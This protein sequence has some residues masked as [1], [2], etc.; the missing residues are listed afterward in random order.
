[1]SLKLLQLNIFHGRFLD[2]IIS[3]IKEND[4][5]II[6]LQEVSS[7]ALSFDKKNNLNELKKALFYQNFFIKTTQ[8]VDK[9]SSSYGLATFIKHTISIKKKE[10]IW[11]KDF[12]TTI[13]KEAI[14]WRKQP[15]AVFA[16]LLQV[17]NKE[18]FVINTHLAWSPTSED[19]DYKIAQGKILLDYLK[20]LRLPFIL[21]G[22]FNVDSSSFIIKEIQKYAKNLLENNNIMNTLNPG[23]HRAKHLFPPGLAVDYIFMHPKI[24]AESFEVLDKDLSD[25][26]GLK[27]EFTF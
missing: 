25:H 14:D 13:S 9:E 10:V 11:L 21:T 26:L 23:L 27:L 16:V 19:T 1:M 15:R 6:Q 17:K 3:Y 18:F 5:D 2:R 22:D 4:F 7:Y 24:H 12:F 8:L 20:Q